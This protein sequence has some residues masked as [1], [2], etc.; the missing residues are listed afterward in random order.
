MSDDPQVTKVAEILDD[1]I[2]PHWGIDTQA[3]AIAI[4][5]AMRGDGDG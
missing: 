2:P 1:E 3:L 5:S 4:V